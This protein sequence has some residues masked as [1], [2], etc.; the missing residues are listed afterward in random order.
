MIGEVYEI[1]NIRA[2]LKQKSLNYKTQCWVHFNG[3]L[4]FLLGGNKNKF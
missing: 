1:F 4:Q 3:E 2:I